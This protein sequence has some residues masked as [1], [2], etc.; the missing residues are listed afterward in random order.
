ME[1]KWDVHIT[2]TV[3]NLDL[4]IKITPSR[5]NKDKVN[6]NCYIT[7][8]NTNKKSI[9]TYEE[10][11]AALLYV[12]FQQ[13]FVEDDTEYQFVEH[14]TN[15]QYSPEDI[16]EKFFTHL[17]KCDEEHFRMGSDNEEDKFSF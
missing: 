16:L 10:K 11:M 9:I 12:G 5:E 7:D 13:I 4:K 8:L 17:K 2:D 3:E 15:T 6:F 14:Q 1:Q